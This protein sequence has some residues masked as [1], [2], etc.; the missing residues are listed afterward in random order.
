M[1]Q[2]EIPVICQY[3]SSGPSAAQVIESSFSTFL[4]KRLQSLHS[5]QAPWYTGSDE[6]P[7]ISGGKICT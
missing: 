3:A 6:H 5:G 4:K 2:Q 7:L 1:S